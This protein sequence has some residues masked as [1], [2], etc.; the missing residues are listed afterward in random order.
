MGRMTVMIAGA[1]LAVVSACSGSSDI[2]QKNPNY[3]GA[4]L[5]DGTISG[6]Y[7]PGG[8]NADLV[9]S[10]INAYCVD[11][12]LGGYSESPTEGGLVA[13]AATCASGTTLSSGFM[14]VERTPDGTFSVE[15][16]GA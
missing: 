7:N 1:A 3:Y 15:I 6:S 11:A 12:R 14:E 13:F 4:K 2:S 10:Q 16:I 9:K 8:F 5:R